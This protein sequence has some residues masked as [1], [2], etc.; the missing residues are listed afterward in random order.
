MKKRNKVFS[1][2]AGLGAASSVALVQCDDLTT[3]QPGEPAGPLLVSRV[4]FLDTTSRDT[5]VFSDT[6]APRDCT[7]GPE[8]QT[9]DCQNNPMKDTFGI[10]KSPPT[11]DSGQSMRVVFNKLPILFM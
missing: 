2:L 5:N 7:N 1:L 4:T 10:K 3:G 8:A 9:P 6:A 11:P